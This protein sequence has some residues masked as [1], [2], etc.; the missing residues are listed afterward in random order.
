ML[1]LGAGDGVG[2]GVGVTDGFAV[3][4][5]LAVGVGVGVAT[6]PEAVNRANSYGVFAWKVMPIGA[7]GMVHVVSVPPIVTGPTIVVH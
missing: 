1:G 7:D 5:G 3:G 4:V 2:L 6:V